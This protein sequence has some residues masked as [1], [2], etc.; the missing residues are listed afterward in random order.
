[1]MQSDERPELQP[2]E[3]GHAGDVDFVGR[4]VESAVKSAEMN[5]ALQNALDKFTASATYANA[6]LCRS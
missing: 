3:P 2:D 6:D 5:P 4:P 1:D